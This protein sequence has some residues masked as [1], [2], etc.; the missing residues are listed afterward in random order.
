VGD[1]FEDLYPVERSLGRPLWDLRFLRRP[2]VEEWAIW[3]VMGF[4][5]VEG[6]NRDVDLN[7]MKDLVSTES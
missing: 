4:A 3:Q 6:I 2:D 7:V 5:H 1:D